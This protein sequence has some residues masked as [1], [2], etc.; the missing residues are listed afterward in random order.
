MDAGWWD[1]FGPD[2]KWIIAITKYISITKYAIERH[3]GQFAYKLQSNVKEM[4][5]L[6][7]K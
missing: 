1:H 3:L 6:E 4:L 5:S 7:Q 2:N